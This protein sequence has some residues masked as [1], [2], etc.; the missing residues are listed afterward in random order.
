ML[1]S[2]FPKEGGLNLIF[3]NFSKI[4]FGFKSSC[5][6]VVIFSFGCA[7]LWSVCFLISWVCCTWDW[8]DVSEGFASSVATCS[9]KFF[10]SF[11]FWLWTSL[12]TSFV[13]SWS[14]MRVAQWHIRFLLIYLT[15]WS[16]CPWPF[17]NVAMSGT[18]FRDF[19][20]LDR[21]KI[22]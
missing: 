13:N 8:I 9:S 6:S 7:V 21:S 17:F 22:F 19:H 20:L 10:S 4:F 14:F 3:F 11:C 2:F 15:R 5:A 16:G 1:E 12:P 18:S